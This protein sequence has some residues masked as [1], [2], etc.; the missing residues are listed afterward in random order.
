MCPRASPDV[1]APQGR[2]ELSLSQHTA[3]RPTQ[4]LTTH[5][6]AASKGELARRRPVSKWGWKSA[7]PQA[8]ARLCQRKGTAWKDYFVNVIYYGL[9]VACPITH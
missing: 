2:P 5:Y 7:A 8:E 6:P 4:T 1:A 9:L 3:L